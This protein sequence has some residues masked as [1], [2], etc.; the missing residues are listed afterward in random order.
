ML[1]YKPPEIPHLFLTVLVWGGGK[2]AA[3]EKKSLSI[4][5]RKSMLFKN[6]LVHILFLHYY[7]KQSRI[8]CIVMEQNYITYHLWFESTD[9]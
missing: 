2:E 1:H 5:N 7:T 4:T 9:R 8:A 6:V 3:V